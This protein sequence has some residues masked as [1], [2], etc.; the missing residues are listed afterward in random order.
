MEFFPNTLSTTNTKKFKLL[1]RDH[2][3]CKLRKK[4]YENMLHNDPNNFFDL[5]SFKY[6]KHVDF[7]DILQQVCDELSSLGWK[8]KTSYGDTALFIYKDDIPIS[9]W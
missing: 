1:L 9:C 6:G 2:I 4:I 3:T 5:S 8:T 7:K